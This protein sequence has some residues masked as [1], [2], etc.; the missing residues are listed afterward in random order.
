MEKK[1]KKEK[2]CYIIPLQSLEIKAEVS[3]LK[4]VSSVLTDLTA[5]H[6]GEGAFCNIDFCRE[7]Q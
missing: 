4:N 7:E 5:L 2:R 3:I 6:K 1:K